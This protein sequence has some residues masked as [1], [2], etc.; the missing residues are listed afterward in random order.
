MNFFIAIKLY[1][2]GE[3]TQ[4]KLHERSKISKNQFYTLLVVE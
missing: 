4:M 1:T 2:K 3:L